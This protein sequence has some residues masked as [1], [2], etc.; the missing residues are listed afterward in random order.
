[1]RCG[2]WRNPE[3][4]LLLEARACEKAVRRFVCGVFGADVR[5]LVLLDNMS[6]VLT[7]SRGRTRSFAVLVVIR[8]IFAYFLRI[9][10]V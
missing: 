9:I 4:I 3:D 2:R 1:M 8:K 7:L 5:Q 6:L 10:T